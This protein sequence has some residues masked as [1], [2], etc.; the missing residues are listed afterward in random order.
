MTRFSKTGYILSTAGSAIGLGGIWGFPYLVGQNGGFAFVLIFVLAFLVFGVS[1]FIVEMVFGRASGQ[2]AVTTFEQFAPKN[3]KFLKFGGF[4]MISG[5]LIFAFYVVVLGWLVHYLFLSI[6]GLP[7]TLETTTEI[8]G[9]CQ[10][11]DWVA[12]ILA[13]FGCR[14]LC[15]CSQSWSKSWD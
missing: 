5:V 14:S 4:M 7:K 11:R 1:V 8:W 13:F 2:N 9:V 6:T 12:S 3:L 15:I 10:Q